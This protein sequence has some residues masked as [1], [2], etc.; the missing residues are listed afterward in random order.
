MDGEGGEARVSFSPLLFSI[1]IGD[2][3]EE[4]KRIKWRG[5]NIGGRRCIP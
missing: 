5:I 2:W 4:M 1:L 3:E